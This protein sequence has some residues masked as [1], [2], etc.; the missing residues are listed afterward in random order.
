LDASGQKRK[1]ALMNTPCDAEQICSV[2]VMNVQASPDPGESRDA[3]LETIRV[4]RQARCVDCASGRAANDSE[5]IR[6]TS[7]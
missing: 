1:N 7:R 4:A 2:D 6:R 3:G 5:R